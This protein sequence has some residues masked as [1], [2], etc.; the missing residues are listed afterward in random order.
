M[1]TTLILRIIGALITAGVLIAGIVWSVSKISTQT[2]V[3]STCIKNLNFN[4][5]SMGK[6][7]DRI[8]TKQ[9]EHETKI[10]VLETKAEIK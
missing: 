7:I 10:A 5:A 4:I 9:D 6:V 3:L 8:G 2:A 1:D